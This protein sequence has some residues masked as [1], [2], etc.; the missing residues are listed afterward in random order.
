[1]GIITISQMDENTIKGTKVKVI[2]QRLHMTHVVFVLVYNLN[3]HFGYP[4]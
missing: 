1:M 2:F 3:L 4:V